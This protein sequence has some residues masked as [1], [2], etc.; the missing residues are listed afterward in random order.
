MLQIAS[1]MYFGDG[2]VN[3]TLHRRVFFTN[4]STLSG[5]EVRLPFGTIRFSTAVD[6]LSTA[7]F[8][9]VD[10]LEALD[11]DGSNAWLISTGGRELL[12]DAASVA[13][14]A[15]NVSFKANLSELERLVSASESRPA[16]SS[17]LRRTFDPGVFLNEAEIASIGELTTQLL[18]LQ[19]PYYEAAMRA[20]QTIADAAAL[21]HDQPAR[22]YMF[23]VAAIEVLSQVGPPPP[24]APYSWDSY[25]GRKRKKIDPALAQI[26]PD[27][28]AVVKDAILAADQ[29]SLSRTFISFA[30]ANIRPMYYRAEAEGAKGPLRAVDVP[31][32]LKVAYRLR[33]RAVHELRELAPE[34]YAITDGSDTVQFKGR[35]V[36]SLQGLSRLCHHVVRTYISLAPTGVDVEFD[37][38]EHLP[39]IVNVN[40]APK[41]WISQSDDFNVQTAPAY[42]SGFLAEL[43]SATVNEDA[44]LVNMTSVLE[45]VEKQ[46]VGLATP[47]QRLP[48]I[49]IYVIWHRLVDSSHHRPD[50]QKIISKFNTD[51]VGPSVV[52]F[53]VH[54]LVGDDPEWSVKQ[55]DALLLQRREDLSRGSGQA[56]P[57]RFDAALFLLAAARHW[58]TGDVAGAKTLI[59]E[60]VESMPGDPAIRK[61]EAD[62]QTYLAATLDLR[63]F[64]LGNGLALEDEGQL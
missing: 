61:M 1:G 52:S 13:A 45:E 29:L 5:D 35:P 16:G 44:D 50:S 40:L 43:L 7:T 41:Y 64:A 57:H 12:A 17:I 60:A 53:A 30:L 26:S 54:L 62:P 11:Q 27:K 14:F 21:A 4:G 42:L 2:K 3:E 46:L 39:G 15:T 32:A 56:L 37:Y 47:A 10:R 6:R 20:I 59:S 28:A 49:A 58:E 48:L 36:F 38:R 18:G 63:Y 55:L 34:L 31:H 33:S 8:E 25:D 51:L 19:R 23:F 22:A 24:P 9:V